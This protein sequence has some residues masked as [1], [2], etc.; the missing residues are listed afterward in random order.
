MR[1]RDLSIRAKVL[2]T[3]LGALVVTLGVATSYSFRYWEREQYELTASHALMMGTTAVGQVQAA[4]AH[5]Q[6]GAARR[7]LDGLVGMPPI[8]GYR[9]VGRDGRILMSSDTSEEGESAT[10]HSLPDPWDIPPEGRMVGGHGTAELGVVLPLS[11]VGGPGGRATLELLIGRDRI[12]QAI[13]RGRTF[14]LTLTAVLALGYAVMLGA[15]M[16]REIIG[17]FRRLEDTVATQQRQLTERAGFAEVGALASEV[18]H[19][20][21]RPLA[22]IRGALELIGQ[23][24]A[25][26]ES[27]RKLLGQMQDELAYVD[28]TIRDLLSLARP[29][30]LQTRPVDVPST[31]DAAL[32]RL[33]GM[34]AAQGVKVERRCDGA[35]PPVAADQA[36]LEQAFLNLCVNAVEA[37]P[38][39][40]S[41]TVSAR[42]HGGE[43]EVAVADTGVGIPRE[44][45]D[46]ILKPF[47]STKP[48][49]TGLGLPLVARVVA[50]HGGRVWVESEVG[51][52]TTVHVALPVREDGWRANGS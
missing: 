27:E 26:S 38:R 49:G 18:A 13:R 23:E 29:V 1:I 6:I 51:K 21:K 16:E 43:V 2:V 37:M 30:G 41:L 20:I 24:Y 35:I 45:L 50:A 28:E 22:G 7:Q 34:P 3:I 5:G 15:M 9:V 8:E 32:A 31:L 39:G 48:H 52:G 4:L 44:N 12:Q 17:P 19:E 33:V 46:R 42:R 10:R 25:M 40:G 36:R 11:N 14:G 47:F